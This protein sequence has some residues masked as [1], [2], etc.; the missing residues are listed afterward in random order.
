MAVNLDGVL[1]ILHWLYEDRRSKNWYL[2][3]QYAR[4]V[5]G[6]DVVAYCFGVGLIDN[7]HMRTC[8]RRD[9]AWALLKAAVAAG[10]HRLNRID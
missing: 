8:E 1:P 6:R 9:D 4:C 2:F 10:Q 3:G 5:C 7:L